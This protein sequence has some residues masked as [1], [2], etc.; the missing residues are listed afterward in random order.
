[1]KLIL[2][3]NNISSNAICCDRRDGSLDSKDVE[4][5]ATMPSWVPIQ[6][7]EDLLAIYSTRLAAWRRW[8]EL[9]GVKFLMYACF[10]K[11]IQLVQ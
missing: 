9:D 5:G 3:M 6:N 4:D 1:M 10:L 2:A 7:S 8:G 11:T